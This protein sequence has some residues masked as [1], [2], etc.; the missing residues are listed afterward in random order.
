MRHRHALGDGSQ[1]LEKGQLTKHLGADRT[2]CIEA[3]IVR[4]VSR[5]LAA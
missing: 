4:Y 5:N 2:V 1:L 3:P